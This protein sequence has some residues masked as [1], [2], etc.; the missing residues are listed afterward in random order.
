MRMAR[1]APSAS[2][3]LGCLCLEDMNRNNRGHISDST[4]IQ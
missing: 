3:L 1:L 2:R 4:V